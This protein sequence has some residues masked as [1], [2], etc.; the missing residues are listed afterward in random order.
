MPDAAGPEWGWQLQVQDN[1]PLYLTTEVTTGSLYLFL[2]VAI[3]QSSQ[4]LV[5][6]TRA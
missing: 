2:M 3:Q 1:G 6:G 5:F 4:I